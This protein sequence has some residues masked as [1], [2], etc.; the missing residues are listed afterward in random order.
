MKRGGSGGG[1][2]RDR[3]GKR[4]I[5]ARPDVRGKRPPRGAGS[6]RA[7][8]VTRTGTW[9]SDSNT[10]IPLQRAF[11]RMLESKDH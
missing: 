11:L 9:W 3:G 5:D 6:D 4:T 1:E 10:R 2:R 8:I 7:V